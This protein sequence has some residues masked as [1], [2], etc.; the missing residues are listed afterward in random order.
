MSSTHRQSSRRRSSKLPLLATFALCSVLGV[1]YVYSLITTGSRPPAS[2]SFASLIDQHG[3]VF[4]GQVGSRSFKLV[5]F[6]YTSCP[7]V[8]PATL[9]RL[10]DVLKALGP[11]DGRLV[12]LFV[13]LDPDRDTPAV[14]ARYASHFDERITGITGDIHDVRALARAYDV[15]PP[16]P[17]PSDG[18]AYVDH[19]AMIYLLG[20]DNVLLAM[21]GPESTARTISLDVR[22][23]T[24]RQDE[25]AAVGAST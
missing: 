1:G 10:H 7:E 13:T 3:H 19:S 24:R 17:K 12:P 15:Y 25:Q 14:L 2:G 16:A 23:R 20:R 21:Y 6:G 9:L 22:L 4:A 11:E 8:C 5:V 18:S